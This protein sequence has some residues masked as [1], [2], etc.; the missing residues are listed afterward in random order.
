MTTR[1]DTRLD[2]G[3]RIDR[4]VTHI[5]DHLDE[6]LD[7]ARLAEVAC[8]SPYHF[9][10]IFKAMTG[11]TVAETL[12]R[13]R[14]NRAAAD[15]IGE[16]GSVQAIA[17]RAGYGSVEAFTRAFAAV[18]G[19]PPAAFRRQGRRVPPFETT[20][21]T[22]TGMIDVT[23]RALET[24]RYAALAHK[25]PYPEIGTTF[26]RL[27]AWAVARNLAD[28][29]ATGL[30]I[31]YD[32]PD[33]VPAAELRADVC[34]AVPDTAVLDGGIR[35][36]EIAGGD[37]AVYLHKGPYA[38]LAQAYRRLCGEWLPQS[39]REPGDGP[40]FEVYLNDC[41]AVPPPEWRTEIH[42]PLAP[43]AAVAA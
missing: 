35:W 17:K 18:Y 27:T 29:A 16:G 13:M 15:L 39:G 33:T 7:F 36:L 21:V 32:D 9:H 42:L 10:R 34:L 25:G 6:P 19:Q 41:R 22:E 23:I 1:R 37:Y 40:C 5:A 11:E 38:E 3:R 4:A 20:F 24:K 31:Y 26:Q 12:R 14:L 43:R 30:A 2:Y 28:P 8:F